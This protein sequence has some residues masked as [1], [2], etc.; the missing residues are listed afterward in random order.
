MDSRSVF[1]FLL[2][3]M[4]AFIL[5]ILALSAGGVILQ[6]P[7]VLGYMF[8]A[9]IQRKKRIEALEKTLSEMNETLKE[10]KEALASEKTEIQ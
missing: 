8:T 7:P 10:I 4:T 6:V 5:L 9:G 2:S 1:L 3:T